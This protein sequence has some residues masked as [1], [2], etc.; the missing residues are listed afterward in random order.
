MNKKVIKV[1]SH[2]KEN[3]IKCVAQKYNITNLN[4]IDCTPIDKTIKNWF[5]SFE[6]KTD[7]NLKELIFTPQKVSAGRQ[8]GHF[9]FKQH[10]CPCKS[11]GTY[12]I[13]N[14]TD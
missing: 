4:L 2:S 12:L 13:I 14:T 3:A 11:T 8:N 10:A 6:D 9:L 1:L 5:E 7:L